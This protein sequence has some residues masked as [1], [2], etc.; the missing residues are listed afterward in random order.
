MWKP[1]GSRKWRRVCEFNPEVFHT[2]KNFQGRP[3]RL[4]VQAAR[5]GVHQGEI[6]FPAS[7]TI[8]LSHDEEA[9]PPGGV[10]SD[11]FGEGIRLDQNSPGLMA[12]LDI[13]SPEEHDLV[14]VQTGSVPFVLPLPGLP[15]VQK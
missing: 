11:K 9:D 8:R 15:G 1:A 2:R 12:S 3:T 7:L 14:G 4:R 6:F 5:K 13:E 10:G